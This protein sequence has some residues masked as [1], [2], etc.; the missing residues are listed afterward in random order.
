MF[1]SQVLVPLNTNINNGL[2]GVRNYDKNI[3][4]KAHKLN[5]CYNIF[6]QAVSYMK[7]SD[8]KITE[9]LCD[10]CIKELLLVCRQVSDLYELPIKYNMPKE[11]FEISNNYIETDSKKYI[12]IDS[13]DTPPVFDIKNINEY[14]KELRE[15]RIL[16]GTIAELPAEGPCLMRSLQGIAESFVGKN[17]SKEQIKEAIKTLKSGDNPIIDSNFKVFDSPA[18]IK[19]ALNRLGVDTSD[20]VI[21]ISRSNDKSYY[22]DAKKAMFSI[23]NTGTITDSTSYGHWQ[24]GDSNGNHGNQFCPKSHPA[25]G[26]IKR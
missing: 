20:L 6:A 7:N 24:Q 8:K 22:D 4:E 1:E 2:Y 25:I 16:S 15:N 14:K 12:D 3:N 9:P 10:D 13:L 17:L 19:D 23:L 26:R 11:D 5:G 21:K 18:V